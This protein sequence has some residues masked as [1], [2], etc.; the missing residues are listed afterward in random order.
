MS[1]RVKTPPTPPTD[2]ALVSD[3]PTDYAHFQP[4]S[5]EFAPL[6]LSE[7]YLRAMVSDTR[8]FLR[9]RCGLFFIHNIEY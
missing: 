8:R 7:T 3:T 4:T 6:N 2:T 1:P 9:L 5:E